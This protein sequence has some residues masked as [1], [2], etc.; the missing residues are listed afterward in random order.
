MDHRRARMELK[1]SSRRLRTRTTTHPLARRLR[2]FCERPK[3]GGPTENS[4]QQRQRPP[5]LPQTPSV[6]AEAALAAGLEKSPSFSQEPPS[7]SAKITATTNPPS[8][9]TCRSTTIDTTACR[10]RS[11]PPQP[12]TLATRITG[13]RSNPSRTALPSR[14]SR[15]ATRTEP[16][17]RGPRLTCH[18]RPAP[19]L[20]LALHPFSLSREPLMRQRGRA[21]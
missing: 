6:L 12:T 13:R 5:A 7:S 14:V 20:E 1:T 18:T 8:I 3:V 19:P 4:S 15:K 21:A 17:R 9:S 11:Q 2:Q 10:R 16:E